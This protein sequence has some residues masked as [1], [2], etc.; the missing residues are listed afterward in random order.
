M[1]EYQEKPV[2]REFE[3]QNSKLSNKIKW[4][5]KLRA[6]LALW[7]LLHWLCGLGDLD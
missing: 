5:W 1:N 6:G 3:T 7:D 2:K 4:L